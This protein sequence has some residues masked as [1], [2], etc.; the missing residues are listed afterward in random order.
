MTEISDAVDSDLGG[1]DE[2]ARNLESIEQ[3]LNDL[4][5]LAATVKTE[6]A[7]TMTAVNLRK[8]AGHLLEQLPDEGREWYKREFQKLGYYL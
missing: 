7:L 3:E 1:M 8:E 2:Q 4:L 5:N 6:F